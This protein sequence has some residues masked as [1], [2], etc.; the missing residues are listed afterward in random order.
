[1]EGRILDQFTGA[2]CALTHIA[3]PSSDFGVAH[4]YVCSRTDAV[5]LLSYFQCEQLM[6]LTEEELTNAVDNFGDTT[7]AVVSGILG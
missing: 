5:P 7:C 3:H 2:V 6:E 4:A 1:M